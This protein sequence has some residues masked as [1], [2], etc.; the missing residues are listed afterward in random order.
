MAIRSKSVNARDKAFTNA[1]NIAKQRDDLDFYNEMMDYSSRYGY[2]DLFVQRYSAMDESQRQK[3]NDLLYNIDDSY[4]A[5]T[6]FQEMTLDLLDNTERKKFKVVKY[7]EDGNP[8]LDETG[9]SYIE[10]ELELTEQEHAK[11]ILDRLYASSKK[12]MAY[13]FTLKQQDNYKNNLEW[14]HKVV[15][16]I[17]SPIQRFTYGAAESLTGIVDFVGSIGYG[18]GVS[19]ATGRDGYREYYEK[20]A[21]SKKLSEGFGAELTEFER[22]YTDYRDTFTGDYTTVGKYLLGACQTVGNMFPYML[23]PGGGAGAGAGKAAKI[24]NGAKTFGYYAGMF[25]TSQS[26]TINDPD[27]ANVSTLSIIFNGALK[28]AVEVAIE[29]ILSKAIGRVTNLDKRLGTNSSKGVTKYIDKMITKGGKAAEKGATKLSRLFNTGGKVLGKYIGDAIQESVEEG[30]QELSGMLIDRMFDSKG[31]TFFKEGWNFQNVF[32]AMIIGGIVS[33]SMSTVEFMTTQR[34]DTGNTVEK[35]NKKG[36]VKLVQQKLSKSESILYK[37]ELSNMYDSYNQLIENAKKK[38]DVDTSLFW[39]AQ[40][41]ESYSILMSYFTGIGAERSAAAL[42]LLE[43]IKHSEEKSKLVKSTA[44]VKSLVD[45]MKG[46]SAANKIVTSSPEF[47]EKMKNAKITQASEISKSS[48]ENMTPEWK[49]VLQ[50]RWKENPDFKLV[51]TDGSDIV[52]NEDSSVI[53]VPEAWFKEGAL[54]VFKTVAEREVVT[55]LHKELLLNEKSLLETIHKEYV[56]WSGEQDS[57][58]EKALYALL[59]DTKFYSVFMYAHWMNSNAWQILSRLND[60]AKSIL[61]GSNIKDAIT[62]LTVKKIERSMKKALMELAKSTNVDYADVTAFSEKDKEEIRQ[63]EFR[64]RAKVVKNLN[65]LK[66]NM[67]L[68]LDNTKSKLNTLMKNAKSDAKKKLIS[69]MEKG[70]NILSNPNSSRVE[71]MDALFMF[72]ALTPEIFEGDT[73]Y[74]SMFTGTS[75]DNTLP[76]DI[77]DIL[78]QDS[79]IDI[80][81]NELTSDD[82]D[83]IL[84]AINSIVYDTDRSQKYNA[85]FGKDNQLFVYQNIDATEVFNQEFL[86]TPLD[87]ILKIKRDKGK[88][89]IYDLVKADYEFSKDTLIILQGTEIYLSTDIEEE[90]S[91][92]YDISLNEIE[93]AIDKNSKDLYLRKGTDIKTLSDINKTIKNTIYHEVNHATRS[94]SSNERYSYAPDSIKLTPTLRTYIREHFPLFVETQYMIEKRSNPDKTEAEILDDIYLSVLYSTDDKEINA[95]NMKSVVFIESDKEPRVFHSNGFNFQDD[96]IITPTHSKINIPLQDKLAY[97]YI[98]TKLKLMSD[99]MFNQSMKEND[100]SM[101]QMGSTASSTNKTSTSGYMRTLLNNQSSA[102]VG[103][104]YDLE[105]RND[106]YRGVK[107]IIDESVPKIYRDTAR[108][109]DVINNPDKYLS[110]KVKEEIKSTYGNLSKSSIMK[111]MQKYF[112]TKFKKKVDITFKDGA[113]VE[114]VFVNVKNFSEYESDLLSSAIYDGSN[115]G[116]TYMVQDNEF[117]LPSGKKKKGVM[118]VSMLINKD[119]N[120]GLISR[121]VVRISETEGPHYDRGVITLRSPKNNNDFRYQ[122]AHEFQHLLD[123]ANSLSGGTIKDFQVTTDMIKDLKEHVPGYIPEKADAQTQIKLVRDYVYH[124]SGERKAYGVTWLDA[125]FVHIERKKNEHI[126]HMPWGGT[127]SITQSGT[128]E[129]RA[130]IILHPTRKSVPIK[131]ARQH[132]LMKHYIKDEHTSIAQ[133]ESMTNFIFDLTEE[134]FK[135]LDEELQEAL[136]SYSMTSAQLLEYVRTTETM[137]QFTFDMINK[138]FFGNPYFKSLKEI[139]DFMDHRHEWHA[140]YKTLEDMGILEQYYVEIM[141]SSKVNDLLEI[142]KKDRSLYDKYIK[143]QEWYFKYNDIEDTTNTVRAS[144]WFNMKGTLL[145]AFR[146]VGNTVFITKKSHAEG[147]Q[148]K[149]TKMYEMQKKGRASENTRDTFKDS[150]HK[151]RET[152][153]ALAEISNERKAQLIADVYGNP[154]MYDLMMNAEISELNAKF[155]SALKRLGPTEAAN[156]LRQEQSELTED[157]VK[158]YDPDVDTYQEALNLLGKRLWRATTKNASMRKALPYKFNSDTKSIDFDFESM[159]EN[160]TLTLENLEEMREEL[161]YHL[162]IAEQQLIGRKGGATKLRYDGLLNIYKKDVDMP[163]TLRVVVEKTANADLGYTNVQGTESIEYAKKSYKSFIDDNTDLLMN[164]VNTPGEVER[165]IEYLSSDPKL[166]MTNEERQRFQAYTVMVLAWIKNMHLEHGLQLDSYHLELLDKCYNMIGHEWGTIGAA[167]RV[168][169]NLVSPTAYMLQEL[170]SIDGIKLEESDIQPLAKAM[171]SGDTN[172]VAEEMA[173]LEQLIYE[174]GGDNKMSV[175]E[176]FFSIRSSFMLSSPATWLRNISSNVI[177]SVGMKAASG[178]GTVLSELIFKKSRGIEEKYHLWKIQ[179]TRV[180]MEAKSYSDSIFN[181]KIYD[182]IKDGLNKYQ[183]NEE[184]GAYKTKK[185]EIVTDENGDPRM[186][187]NNNMYAYMIVNTIKKR[188]YGATTFE[189]SM[190]NGKVLKHAK[191]FG[192]MMDKA[193]KLLAKVLSDEKYIKARARYYFERM[194]TESVARGDIEQGDLQN[195]VLTEKIAEILGQAFTEACADYMHKGSFLKDFENILYKRYKTATRSSAKAG[196]AAGYA[197]YKLLLPYA[198]AGWNWFRE[199][200]KYSPLGLLSGVFKLMNLE[201]DINANP[202]E[203]MIAFRAKQDFGKGIIGTTIMGI[204]FVLAK[205]GLL[206]YDEE[207]DKILVGDYAID[208]SA[209]FGSPSFTLGVI[210]GFTDEEYDWVDRI[211]KSGSI[212]L[213]GFFLVDF[214]DSLSYTSGGWTGFLNNT[215]ENMIQSFIPNIWKQL[216]K[217]HQDGKYK[218]PKG[219]EGVRDRFFASLIPNWADENLEKKVDPYTGE[220]IEKWSMP[221]WSRFFDNTFIKVDKRIM[222]D[223]EKYSLEHGVAKSQDDAKWDDEESGSWSYDYDEYNQYRGKLNRDRVSEFMNDLVS[224]EVT[225]NNKKVKLK[226]SQMTQEELNQVL[227]RIYTQNSRYAKIWAWTQSGNKYYATEDMYIILKK[228]GITNIY[229]KDKK[230]SGFVKS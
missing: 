194:I 86:D 186:N 91:G 31:E 66:Q 67:N 48:I 173:K 122:F 47:I 224:Y 131:P 227:N 115:N 117:E 221:F 55:E 138:H 223:V 132:W 128:Q 158:I 93:I 2:Q 125:D 18:I 74:L 219:F 159:E 199:G 141:D 53:M 16:D 184:K 152:Q 195:G 177:L 60:V 108:I 165:V 54:D 10:E 52:V 139:D 196:Y 171:R 160:G 134:N 183:Y 105:F 178:V 29:K 188:F 20:H 49:K 230:H 65:T 87:F 17:Y 206:G 155:M 14:Y 118:P 111:Y 72:Y 174:R 78:T 137:N 96:Y 151:T 45:N 148:D 103:N 216:T 79:P 41:Y 38:G 56:E 218:Y 92:S 170:S 197:L 208:I 114:V 35:V 140:L 120:F 172:R 90:I 211:E 168:A 144:S 84:D 110:E 40:A 95:F 104:T 204:A 142:I 150:V 61:T 83:K 210:L 75:S 50:E 226:A 64:N 192:K 190:E 127:W 34:I 80:D 44:Y 191:V 179:G 112:Y 213:D 129:G 126:A 85:T 100:V 1:Y 201:K 6:A 59:Y 46:A 70:Y 185:G 130:S 207:E 202:D 77:V 62:K 3:I 25:A 229:R 22:L 176:M 73:Y 146:M 13:D 106:V 68:D 82:K 200:I 24:I 23:I 69:L 121:A 15:N 161:A 175:L 19:I 217:L 51:S 157:D 76:K 42:T 220:Y 147:N 181:S 162:R 193:N 101:V 27:F 21:L 5:Q 182:M 113:K 154:A 109:N 11:L 203:K 37:T 107:D 43:E 187:M 4:K 71:V 189:K 9:E 156:A 123:E 8:V 39:A 149:N 81:P 198:N 212:L 97:K 88:V 119:H 89:T 225:R 98:N 215:A 58:V 124:R 36:E 143:Y 164:M 63:S 180:T 163:M 26:A 153:G 57:S 7:D 205:S 228:L 145:D 133:T 166:F 135:L 169:V 33:G 214:I 102:K 116:L 12:K 32:D 167:L 136:L 99:R 222:S 94:V 28:T 209:L 30:L